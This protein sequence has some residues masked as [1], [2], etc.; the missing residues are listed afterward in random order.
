MNPKDG[1][2]CIAKN[3]K[4]CQ[5]IFKLLKYDEVENRSL[6]YCRPITGR[7]HQIRLHLQHLG[8]PIINDPIYG[9]KDEILFQANFESS[10]LLHAYKYSH[11]GGMV[12]E[13]KIPT[14]ARL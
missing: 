6:V 13:T 10:I 9:I 5:T 1:I 4:A 14:W 2:Y 7:T 3:G 8:F 11:I 12:F